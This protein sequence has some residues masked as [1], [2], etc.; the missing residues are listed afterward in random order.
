MLT[1]TLT[2]SRNTF[3]ESIRQPIYGVLLLGVVMLLVLG[4]TWSAYTFDDD[5]VQLFD[6][7]LGMILAGG[8]VLAAFIASG[9]LAREI[10]NKTALTV[11]SKP[12]GRPSFVIGKY[13][14]VAGAMT[15][16]M[17]IWSVV[18]LLTVR[19]KVMSAAA[20]QYDWPVLG[21]ALATLVV[22]LMIAVWGNYFYN[23]VFTSTFTAALSAGLPAAFIGVLLIDPQWTVQ[24]ITAEFQSTGHYPGGQV[25]LALIAVFDAVWLLCAVAIAASTRL[26]QVMTLVICVAFLML[27]LVSDPLFGT[28]AHSSTVAAT[29]YWIAPNLQIFFLADALTKN[30]TITLHH[31]GMVTAY[32]ALYAVAVLGIA[33]ALFQTRETG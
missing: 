23:W 10:D 2:I 20:D 30:A 31:I 24:P 9:V 12:I 22:A 27:G 16:A 7:G 11:I 4:A 33:V 18:F 3:T 28:H 15:L 8:L 6:M 14:G 25:L 32:A 21:F 19:H 26:G 1:Q 5:T 17:L 29:A 13:L